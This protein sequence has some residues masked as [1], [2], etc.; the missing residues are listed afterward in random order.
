[1]D[2]LAAVGRFV[3]T[4]PNKDAAF[5]T[6]GVVPTL[7][8]AGGSLRLVGVVLGET[9]MG[10]I[11]QTVVC[12]QV[13]TRNEESIRRTLMVLFVLGILMKVE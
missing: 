4:T 9:E 3:A 7:S 11:A 12:R 6:F 8:N 5:G 2:K 10:D 13:K 1:M